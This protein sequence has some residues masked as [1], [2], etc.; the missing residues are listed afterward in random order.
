MQPLGRK[1]RVFPG[2]EDIHP[3]KRFDEGNWWD[4]HGGCENKKAS[5]RDARIQIR[6][7]LNELIKNGV[8]NKNY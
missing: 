1:P 4:D 6:K 7:K 3:R 5:R 8:I 2:K